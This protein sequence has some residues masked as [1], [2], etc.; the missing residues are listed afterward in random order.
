VLADHIIEPTVINH[1]DFEQSD[2]LLVTGDGELVD[3][4]LASGEP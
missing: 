2:T 3:A 1:T 4:K